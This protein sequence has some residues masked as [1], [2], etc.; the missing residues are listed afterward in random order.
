MP[1]PA[2][3]SNA[4]INPSLPAITSLTPPHSDYD[5]RSSSI[6]PHEAPSTS[7]QPSPD[8]WSTISVCSEA[9]FLAIS[10]R[11]PPSPPLP[12]ISAVRAEFLRRP[13]TVLES[14]VCTPPLIARLLDRSLTSNN[15][16]TV[17]QLPRC[18][19]LDTKTISKPKRPIKIASILED[20]LLQPPSRLIRDEKMNSETSLTAVTLL[21][22][23]STAPSSRA[24]SRSRSYRS[25]H[26]DYSLKS[27]GKDFSLPGSTDL[28]DRTAS[29][30]VPNFPPN[31]EPSIRKSSK[32]SLMLVSKALAGV[33]KTTNAQLDRYLD[34][35]RI[36]RVE[37]FYEQEL[38]P[39]A[40]ILNIVRCYVTLFRSAG[41]DNRDAFDEWAKTEHAAIENVTEDD[42]RRLAETEDRWDNF[43][44]A[45]DKALH[46]FDRDLIELDGYDAAKICVYDGH[47]DIL[48][49]EHLHQECKDLA[50]LVYFG[51]L[52]TPASTDLLREVLIDKWEYLK[53]RHCKPILITTTD[54]EVAES[55]VQPVTEVTGVPV[56]VLQDSGEM[57]EKLNLPISMLQSSSMEVI[58]LLASD[59]VSRRTA[60]PKVSEDSVTD[61]EDAHQSTAILICTRDGTIV[62]GHRMQSAIERLDLNALMICLNQPKIKL[63]QQQSLGIRQQQ[64]LDDGLEQL[65]LEDSYIKRRLSTLRDKHRRKLAMTTPRSRSCA[66]L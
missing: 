12:F 19:S 4:P 13:S 65:V 9:T 29:E 45:I 53:E 48:L 25:L 14:P 2:L 32:P 23:L 24:Q 61:F 56:S 57:K 27:T 66:I 10:P 16:S 59:L 21:S 6:S 40:I 52:H 42:M 26:H 43:L 50:L 60:L 58:H 44:Y 20:D 30:I 47:K 3:S 34:E 64:L 49:K 54:H 1:S 28:D 55:W 33:M 38:R 51:A 31:S 62:L 8:R 39:R 35:I 22:P 41:V 7:P 37:P 5:S 11:P 18:H 36:K 46:D 15:Y 17:R 63:P